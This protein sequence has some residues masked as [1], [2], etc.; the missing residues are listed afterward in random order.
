MRGVIFSDFGA[1]AR[2]CLRALPDLIGRIVPSDRKPLK[3]KLPARIG[4]LGFAAK[5]DAS[6]GPRIRTSKIHE[7]AE[8]GARL[9][10]ANRKIADGS[11]LR[12]RADTGSR[13]SS[14]KG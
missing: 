12:H 8:R 4:A 6:S 11:A 5:K 1:S 13:H 3:P 10:R 14:G 2:S 7:Y 9:P